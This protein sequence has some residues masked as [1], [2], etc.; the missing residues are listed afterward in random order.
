MIANDD[1]D[2][3]YREAYDWIVEISESPKVDLRAYPNCDEWL[4]KAIKCQHLMIHGAKI[5]EREST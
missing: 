3:R 5:D 1:G 2:R 4:E